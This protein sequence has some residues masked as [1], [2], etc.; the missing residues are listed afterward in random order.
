MRWTA[1]GGTFEATCSNSLGPPLKMSRSATRQ[2]SVC[3]RQ[4]L[5]QVR[6]EL[7][8]PVPGAPVGLRLIRPEARLLHAQVGPGARWGERERHDT[9]QIE[10]RI[11]VGKIPGV[12]QRSFGS[13]ARTSQSRT[14]PQSPRRLKR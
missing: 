7:L 6:K 9:L 8:P 3:P 10:R 12:G 5:L 13:T 1:N 4:D 2:T 11:V 14:P